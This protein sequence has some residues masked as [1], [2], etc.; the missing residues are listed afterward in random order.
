MVA[1][2]GRVASG[3][4]EALRDL[5]VVDRAVYR[6]VADT[7]IP[8]LDRHFRRL[9]NAANY[10]RLWLGMA[11]LIAILVVDEGAV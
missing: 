9:S 11:A 1:D 10:S 8:E 4:A 2:R 7:P 5:G 6:A 3:W